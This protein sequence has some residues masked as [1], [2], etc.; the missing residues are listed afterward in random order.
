MINEIRLRHGV[1]ERVDGARFAVIHVY[2][3]EGAPLSVSLVVV[4][5]EEQDYEL[6]IGETFPVRNETWM[7]DCVENLHSGGNWRVVLR[8]AGY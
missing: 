1:P 7:L 5:G 6:G 8:K 2:A 3:P 4:A